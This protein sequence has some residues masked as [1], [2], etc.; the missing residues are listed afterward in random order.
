MMEQDMKAV[1][2]GTKSKG[3]VLETCLHQMKNCFLDVS[4]RSPYNLVTAR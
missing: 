2:L 1:S 4:L 3:Q